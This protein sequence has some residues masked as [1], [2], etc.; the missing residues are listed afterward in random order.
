MSRLRLAILDLYNGIPNQGMRCIRQIVEGFADSVEYDVFDVRVDGKVPDLSYDI[1]LSSGGPGDPR[2]GAGQEGWEAVWN[3]WLE[4]V[5]RYNRTEDRKKWVFFICHSFQMA[6]H[7]FEL[8]EVVP[9]KG[10]SFG[11]FPIHPEAVGKEDILFAELE[12][13]FWAADFRRYQAI[14]PDAE[15]LEEVG[16]SILALEKIRPHVELERAIM[17]VRWSREM[18]GVQF[19]PEADAE[20]MLKHFSRPDI[21]QEVIAD[22]GRAK[23]LQMMEDLSHPER[24]GKT[25]DTVLPS[26]LTRAIAALTTEKPVTL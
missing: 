20:G 5:Y 7:H 19:H 22:H 2:N 23:W 16:A 13:P 10:I 9:R 26:F 1:Y 14:Q 11:T 17:A 21:K 4:T 18:V 25:H 6:I 24:I 8:A 12:D 3:D 15:K